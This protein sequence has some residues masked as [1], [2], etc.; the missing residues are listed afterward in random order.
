MAKAREWTSRD[1]GSLIVEHQT[2]YGTKRWTV[3]TVREVIP[4]DN[5]WPL[6]D[7]LGKL[8]EAAEILL[9]RCDYDGHGY[10]EFLAA[11]DRAKELV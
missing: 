5:P 2:I 8:V 11:I 7:V 4:D 9:H 1:G 3:E 10:E 6:R